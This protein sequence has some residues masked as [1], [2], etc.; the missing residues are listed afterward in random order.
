MKYYLLVA[1]AVLLAAEEGMK[2]LVKLDPL[3]QT[4]AIIRISWK[5]ETEERMEDED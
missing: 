4:C 1:M 3:H 2:L 5:Q